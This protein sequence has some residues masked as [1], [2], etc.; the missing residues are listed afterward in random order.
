MRIKYF[1]ITAILVTAVLCSAGFVKAQTVDNS[2]LI[3]Q[4]KAQIQ[5]LMQQIA[6]LQDQQSTTQTWCHTFN[7]NIGVGVKKGNPE[8]DALTVALQKEGIIEQGTT[9][10]EGYDENL[11]SAVTGFQEKYTSEILTPLNLKHGTGYIGKS[12]RAKLNA[13]YGCQTVCTQDAKQCPDGS[14]VSRTGPS[15]E[16]AQCPTTQCTTDSDCPQP[17][18]TSPTN[19]SATSTCL[20]SV[21]KCIN[22]KCIL[23]PTTPSITVTSPNGGE[24]WAIGETH[25]ITWTS[26]AGIIGN[27]AVWIQQQGGSAP[28]AIIASTPNTGSASWTIPANITP[29][30]NYRIGV[31]GNNNN[32]V[33]W[34]NNNLTITATNT[35]SITVTSPNGGEQ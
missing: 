26:T 11:A 24:T 9:F 18:C 34:S 32:I 15:C 30:N 22:G 10:S 17:T 6:A 5:A 4:L 21:N 35:P 23:T 27:V 33:D 3:A 13:L 1:L 25:N 14:Y 20:G 8:I 29:A 31:S 2:A 16:F 7:A 28:Q 12:T 19:T